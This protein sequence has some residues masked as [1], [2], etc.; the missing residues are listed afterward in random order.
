MPE[1]DDDLS[2]HRPE[3]EPVGYRQPP[4]EHQFQPGRSGNPKG[5]P[6]GSRGWKQIIRAVLNRKVTSNEN[7]RRKQIPASEAVLLQLMK[8]ALSGDPA[9]I[10]TMVELMKASDPSKDE[11]QSG[12]LTFIIEE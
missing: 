11:P 2:S 8:K 6:K 3:N 9:A 4:R 10:K 12:G 7:G 1:N 5:R